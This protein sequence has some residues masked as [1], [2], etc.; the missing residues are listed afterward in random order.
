MFKFH[1]L[2]F[3]TK[4]QFLKLSAEWNFFYGAKYKNKWSVHFLGLS[5]DPRAMKRAKNSQDNLETE[6][7]WRTNII[8]VFKKD[9]L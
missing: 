1:E 9:G 6:Q 4:D 3:S 8:R 7:S 5:Q 2:R